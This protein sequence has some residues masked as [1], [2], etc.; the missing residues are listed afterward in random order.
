MLRRRVFAGVLVLGLAV[1]ADQITKTCVRDSLAVGE[2]FHLFGP[3]HLTH[4]QNTGAVFGLGQGYT[5]VPTIASIVVLALIPLILRHMA[6]HHH[7]TP[8][9]FEASSIGLIAGG[10]VGNLIDRIA[11]SA[12]TDFIDIE[13]LPGFRWPAFNVADSCIVIGTILILIVLFR[14]AASEEHTPD[15]H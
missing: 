3:V 9:L 7:Y 4:V 13:V 2:S 10:A 8:N 11:F 15:G 14:H 6:V 1:V 5:V 12:V